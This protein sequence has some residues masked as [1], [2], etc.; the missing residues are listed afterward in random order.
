MIDHLYTVSAAGNDPRVNLAAESALMDRVHKNEMILYLWQNDNTVVIGRNQNVWKEC[1]LVNIERDHVALVRRS[2]GGGAVYHDL[3]NLN[4]TFITDDENY[5]VEKQSQVIVKALEK[6]GLKAEI[7]GRNDLLLN[8]FKFSGNAYYHHGGYSYHHGTLLISSDLSKM[9]I[10]LNPDPL[11]LKTNGVS[12]VRSRVANLSDFRKD[13]NIKLVKG[14]LIKAAEEIYG[15][16]AEK[17]PFPDHDGL[18]SYLR[19]YS[20]REWIYGKN[21]PFDISL[22]KRFAW[23]GAEIRLRIIRGI[24]QDCIIHSD[25]MD[26]DEIERIAEKLKGCAFE[27]TAIMHNIP[28]DSQIARDLNEWIR[29]QEF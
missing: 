19:L 20:S 15:C 1:S 18:D 17:M 23:G 27:R 12:S 28:K 13:L 26:P 10:Y 25:S 14:L 5:D 2:S 6:A 21:P 22:S 9:P 4:F 11:K 16:K 24:I 3:G 8:G 29:E 7:S